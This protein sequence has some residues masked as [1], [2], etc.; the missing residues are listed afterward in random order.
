MDCSM[1]ASSAGVTVAIL[2]TKFTAISDSAGTFTFDGVPAG[3]YSFQFSKLGFTT[4][5]QSSVPFVG[6]GTLEEGV[7]AQLV[8]IDN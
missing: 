5:V 2:G 1:S 7:S 4:F 3:Y 8:R 6:S